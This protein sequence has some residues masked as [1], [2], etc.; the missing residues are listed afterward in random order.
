MVQLARAT[1]PKAGLDVDVD[2]GELG[3]CVSERAAEVRP[4]GLKAHGEELERAKARPV[5][6]ANPCEHSCGAMQGSP[7][8]AASDP[9]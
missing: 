2:D 3:V 7:S 6:A 8:N 9:C 1:S 4:G 5:A